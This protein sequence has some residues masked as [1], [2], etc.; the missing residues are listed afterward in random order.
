[1]TEGHKEFTWDARDNRGE[2][3]A[4]GIYFYRIATEDLVQTKK[5]MLLQ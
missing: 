1:M 3:V 2:P 5:M 4:S